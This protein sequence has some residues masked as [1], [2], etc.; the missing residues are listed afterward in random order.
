MLSPKLVAFM[1]IIWAF[2]A[3][4]G[5]SFEHHTLA[6]DWTGTATDKQ[7]ATISTLQYLMNLKNATHQFS[8]F[9]LFSMPIPNSEWLDALWNVLILRFSFITGD[10]EMFYYIVLAPF[11]VMA[12]VSLV[13]VAV[14]IVRGQFPW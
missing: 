6:A 12:F 14:S 8:V 13:M 2:G 1:V 11:V 10:F 3:I 4:L 7:Y 5:S 9:G